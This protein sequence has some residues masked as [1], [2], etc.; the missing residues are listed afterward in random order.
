LPLLRIWQILFHVLPL[1]DLNVKEA[2]RADVQN[3]GV[4]GQFPVS[5]QVRVIAPEV[6]RPELI[7]RFTMCCWKCSTAFR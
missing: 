1:K 2:E 6:V 4:D 5:E 7:E 3:N